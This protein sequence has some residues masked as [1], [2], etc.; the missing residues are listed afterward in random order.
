MF[1]TSLVNSNFQSQISRK[2]LFLLLTIDVTW[3]CHCVLATMWLLNSIDYISFTQSF[4]SFVL[5]IKNSYVIPWVVLEVKY[6]FLSLATKNLNTN[7]YKTQSSFTTVVRKEPLCDYLSSL[8]IELWRNFNARNL[9][10]YKCFDQVLCSS[11]SKKRTPFVKTLSCTTLSVSFSFLYHIYT[12]RWP[13]TMDM[14]Y[15]IKTV[16]IHIVR[17]FICRLSNI[18]WNIK[19]RKWNKFFTRT[20]IESKKHASR[21]AS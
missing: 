7:W 12:I 10:W 2:W 3:N 9:R 6:P 4:T 16:T 8:P 14:F 18:I 15:W 20:A 5:L 17:C 11:I 1:T 19:L 13:L 21:V